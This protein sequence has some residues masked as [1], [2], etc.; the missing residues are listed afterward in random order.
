[1]SSLLA[2]P[3]FT[4][5]YWGP[6]F[7]ALILVPLGVATGVAITLL[8]GLFFL[9]R[10]AVR[11][12]AAHRFVTWRKVVALLLLITLVDIPVYVQYS[13][14][15]RHESNPA[16]YPCERILC[17]DNY[18]PV[19]IPASEV[20][21]SGIDFTVYLPGPPPRG[22]TQRFLELNPGE[23][24]V[25][26]SYLRSQTSIVATYRLDS[27]AFELVEARLGPYG[28][29]SLDD[30]LGAAQRTPAGRPVYQSGNSLAVTVIGET[31]VFISA[32]Y[33]QE[34]EPLRPELSALVDSLREAPVDE[35]VF[36]P[37]GRRR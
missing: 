2:G 36:K 13:Y 12:E 34:G 7:L 23:T 30:N 11:P 29:V 32:Y 28:L 8:Y 31:M 24:N 26:S 25:A 16:S 10:R 3:I 9:M 1:M 15:S 6:L 19:T 37:K 21:T 14:I 20:D 4:D 35:L 17:L 22:F 33:A 18:F 27:S 5:W